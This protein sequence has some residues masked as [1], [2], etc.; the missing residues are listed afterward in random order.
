MLR[1]IGSK[2]KYKR[3]GYSAPPSYLTSVASPSASASLDL[4]EVI[5]HVRGIVRSE[6]HVPMHNIRATTTAN[7]RGLLSRAER[8]LVN[9]KATSSPLKMSTTQLNRDSSSMK[10]APVFYSLSLSL[11]LFHRDSPATVF[12][13]RLERPTYDEQ[14]IYG[15][16]ARPRE[17]K[18]QRHVRLSARS[19]I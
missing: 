9:R 1:D 18:L 16:E 3:L 19:Q 13:V 14:S 10:C 15:T 8:A 5:P 17:D 2:Y 4:G 6:R 11:S 12:T 7:E